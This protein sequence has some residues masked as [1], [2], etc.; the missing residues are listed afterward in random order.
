VLRNHILRYV[1]GLDQ[2]IV[3]LLIHLGHN[4]NLLGHLLNLLL[5]LLPQL[6]FLVREGATGIQLPLQV[7]ETG[8]GLGVFAAQPNLRLDALVQFLDG[9]F[10]LIAQMKLAV[11]GLSHNHDLF[12]FR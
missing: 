11:E 4:I 10:F 7:Q 5:V 9:D 2:L 8:E 1:A 3:R 6:N 12:R